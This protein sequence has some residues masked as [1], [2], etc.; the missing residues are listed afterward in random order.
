MKLF[1]IKGR[2]RDGGTVYYTGKQGETAMSRHKAYA[3]VFTRGGADSNAR[4]LVDAMNKGHAT[5]GIEWEIT[6]HAD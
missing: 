4:R 3:R 5:H 6:D 1:V 2:T